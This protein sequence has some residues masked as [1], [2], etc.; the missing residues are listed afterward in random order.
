MRSRQIFDDHRIERITPIINP[1][2]GEPHVGLA[3]TNERRASQVSR[4]RG[5]YCRALL[6]ARSRLQAKMQQQSRSEVNPMAF[7]RSRSLGIKILR[8]DRLE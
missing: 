2:Q 1:D 6:R 7:N 8:G 5:I 3:A 4:H